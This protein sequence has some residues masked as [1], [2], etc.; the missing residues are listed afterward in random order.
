MTKF[1]PILKINQPSLLTVHKNLPI[2][3]V[4]VRLQDLVA[5]TYQ[6]NSIFDQIKDAKGIHNHLGFEGNV[7]LSSIMR[8]DIIPHFDAE[9][10][11]LA[12][13]LLKPNVYTTPDCETYEGETIKLPDGRI[14]YGN[15]EKSLD[16]IQRSL[17]ITRKLIQLC[18]DSAPLGQVKG[19][20]IAQL[21]FHMAQLKSLEIYDF[22]FHV[23]DFFRH[24]NPLFIQK[25][26]SYAAF[27]KRH[28]RT[29]ML[30]GMGSQNKLCEYS[31]A[32]SYASMNYF[33]KARRGQEYIG[34]KL[35]KA[36]ERYSPSLA[37]KNLI[38]ML[39]NMRNI[40]MQT[41]LIE[42]LE[43]PAW[44]EDIVSSVSATPEEVMAAEIAH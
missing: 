13:N 7:I 16:Q 8:D 33:I 15:V 1:F 35:R 36:N 10:Y 43:V 28:S 27:I 26:K 22:V 34:T 19:C 42:Y 12:I 39:K 2:N 30:Y 41:K 40:S 5:P 11:A 6:F 37:R 21:K 32:D 20:N 23:G 38:Q 25:A 31:F 9:K 18:P 4:I 14:F 17:L 24:G 3:V 29:L 44:E